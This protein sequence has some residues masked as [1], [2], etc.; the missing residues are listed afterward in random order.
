MG[1]RYPSVINGYVEYT[2]LL[3]GSQNFQI[4]NFDIIITVVEFLK[5][6]VN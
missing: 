6:K 1:D 4:T 5:K 3:I 2:H